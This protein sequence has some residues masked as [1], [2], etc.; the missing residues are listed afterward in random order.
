MNENLSSI[1]VEQDA[2]IP[3]AQAIWRN[4]V[5]KPLYVTGQI[6]THSFDLTQDASSNLGRQAPE[7]ALGG[8][9]DSN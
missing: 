9:E 2:P 4:K 8:R 7:F 6:V 3:D 5:H 1:N